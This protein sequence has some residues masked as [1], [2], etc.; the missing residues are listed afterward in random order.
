[1]SVDIRRGTAADVSAVVGLWSTSAGPTRLAGDEAAVRRLLARDP[2][3]LL[4][5]VAD[6]EVVGM[7]IVGFDGWRCHLYRMA[8]PEEHRRK[9]IAA[10]LVDAAVARARALGAGR[11]DAMVAD[12]NEGGVAFWRNAGF[13]LDTDDSRWSRLL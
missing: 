11:L 12:E 2:D 4:V 3:S 10:R 5:A 6:G 7:L 1:M 13:E 8:V 9:G